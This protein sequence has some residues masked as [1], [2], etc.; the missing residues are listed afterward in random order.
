MEDIGINTECVCVCMCVCVCVCVCVC[1]FVFSKRLHT[2][3]KS[4]TTSENATIY[5]IFFLLQ[6]TFYLVCLFLFIRQQHYSF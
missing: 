5:I 4:E 3:H 6:I 1:L 2:V